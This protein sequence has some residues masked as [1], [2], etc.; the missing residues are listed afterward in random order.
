MPHTP[1]EIFERVTNEFDSL[2][3]NAEGAFRISTCQRIIIAVYDLQ[4][5]ESR[6]HNNL[7]AS[8][9]DETLLEYVEILQG[10]SAFSYLVKVTSGLKSYVIGE[11]QITHQMKEA[12]FS[13]ESDGEMEK[14]L[15]KIMQDVFRVSSR[16]Q[17]ETSIP[18]GKVSVLSLIEDKIRDFGA[19][20]PPDHNLQIGIIGT[21]EMAKKSGK[22]V[23]RLFASAKIHWYTDREDLIAE[24]YFR[25]NLFISRIKLY[26]L[27]FIAAPNLLLSSEDIEEG[28]NDPQ[29]YIDL[30]VP[31]TIPEIGDGSVH[32]V[33]T[34]DHLK[35]LSE[36][37]REI[38]VSSI[39]KAEQIIGEYLTHR[40][41]RDVL[42]KH[43]DKLINFRSRLYSVAQVKKKDIMES[44]GSKDIEKKL[45]VAINTLLHHAQEEYKDLLME[46]YD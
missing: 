15:G 7:G 46:V 11:T 3:P 10:D 12:F 27:V 20:L 26:D 23:R 34:L 17:S 4:G 40:R 14:E 16:I 36:K 30:T 24:N 38:R 21:G 32:E 28:R 6:I 45:D 19:N 29:L 1:I 43:K 33:I 41:K 5:L 44:L 9:D 25:K 42:T 37:N 18:L 8:D 31:R 22:L 2:L 35:E 39:A 13:A